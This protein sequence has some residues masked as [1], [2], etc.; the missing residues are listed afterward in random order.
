MPAQ[1][2]TLRLRSPDEFEALLG[3]PVRTE[4]IEAL[5]IAGEACP[6]SELARLVGRKPSALYHHLKKLVDAGLVVRAGTG[7]SG[8]RDEALFITA[9][10]QMRVDYDAQDPAAIDA[11]RRGA[12]AVLRTAE[13]DYRRCIEAAAAEGAALPP[14]LDT[15]RDKAW[16]T[17]KD[18]RELYRRI[19]DLRGFLRARSRPGR[20]RLIALTISAAGLPMRKE[21]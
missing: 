3:S 13:R 16:L 5:Q 2:A 4:L 11:I 20:G 10:R 7:K 8:P 19:E 9:A 18:L 6:V 12:A 14:V 17:T 1:R 15:S 21:R